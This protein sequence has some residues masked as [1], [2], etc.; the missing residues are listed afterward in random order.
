M[1]KYQVTLFFLVSV[2]CSAGHPQTVGDAGWKVKMH[3][4]LQDTLTLIPYAFDDKKFADP[5]NRAAIQ[6]SMTSLLSHV[7]D[8]KK[9]IDRNVKGKTM[10]PS[11]A[12][13]AEDFQEDL[14]FAN[15][16]FAQPAVAG[17]NSQIYLKSS[18]SRCLECHTQSDA[19]PEMQINAFSKQIENLSA[20]D[21]ILAF[22]S[23][24]QFDKALSE[25]NQ[26]TAR[27]DTAKMD[28]FNFEHALRTALLITIRVKNDPEATL[29]VLDGALN[30][31][32]G[33]ESIKV[34]MRDWK[35]SVVSWKGEKTKMTLTDSADY[36]RSQELFYLAKAKAGSFDHYQNSDILLLRSSAYLHHL[37]ASYP[38]SQLRAKSF[39]LLA[40]I[41]DGL[42]GF[43]VWE[44]PEQYLSRCIRENPKTKIVN[45]VCFAMTR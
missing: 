18:L 14:T 23:T 16:M 1:R 21:K 30:S 5:K 11:L 32:A 44:L 25:F 3:G 13:I 37:L 10:D 6:T 27:P 4:L 24:R 20:P 19:G 28:V 39:L 33:S 38:K 9:H 8:L 40:Q 31:H 43:A 15:A 2:V 17:R 22:A 12:V 45:Q 41:Y 36:D 35:K 26:M 42:P 7:D 29:K 34:D